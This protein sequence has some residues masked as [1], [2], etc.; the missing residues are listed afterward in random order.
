[1]NDLSLEA[2]GED[3]RINL[4]ICSPFILISFFIA[5]KFLVKWR[6]VVNLAPP[7][8]P[9]I[10]PAPITYQYN[11]SVQSAQAI[12]DKTKGEKHVNN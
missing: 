10:S 1:M 8:L 6:E 7:S 5:G 11:I 4:M 2:H 9:A 12:D 3:A